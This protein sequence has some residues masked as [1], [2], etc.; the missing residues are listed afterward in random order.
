MFKCKHKNII[1]KFTRELRLDE[2]VLIHYEYCS[3]CKTLLRGGVSFVKATIDNIA[4]Q[5][6]CVKI[7]N[8][9]ELNKGKT[10][11]Q[12]VKKTYKRKIKMAKK[13][14]SDNVLKEVCQKVVKNIPSTESIDTSTGKLVIEDTTDKKS[15]KKQSY[16]KRRDAEKEALDESMV[17]VKGTKDRK[18]KRRT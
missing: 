7:A 16:F 6:E 9:S 17:F 1:R 12:I 15:E 10:L 13:E 8:G 2:S 14:S 3:D 5:T 18:R 4:I 11:G